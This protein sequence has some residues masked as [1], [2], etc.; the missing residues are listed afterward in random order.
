M[1]KASASRSSR[2]SQSLAS[3]S[4]PSRRIFSYEDLI[5]HGKPYVPMARLDACE[6]LGDRD[7]L[8]NDIEHHIITE[9]IPV[10]ISNVL[11][12]T[13]KD[14]S[15]VQWNRQ[16]FAPD[17][18]EQNWPKEPITPRHLL[19]LQDE[20]GFTVQAYLEIVRNA[21]MRSNQ[22]SAKSLYAH[23]YPTVYAKDL[24][25]PKE[26]EDHMR[27]ILDERLIYNGPTDCFGDLPEKLRAINLMVYMGTE[28]TRT[29]S[30]TDICSS[31]GHN[32]MVYAEDDA[33]SIWFVA[34]RKNKEKACA[35]WSL[36]KGSVE[37]DDN[38]VTLERFA[39]SEFDVFV[40]KQRLG[41]FVL[42]PSDS[43]HQVVNKGGLSVKMAWNRHT[44]RSLYRFFDCGLAAH[45]QDICKTETYRNK[46]MVLHAIEK[47]HAC[48]ESKLKPFLTGGQTREEDLNAIEPITRELAQTLGELCLLLKLY[49]SLILDEII[50]ND[51]LD[52]NMANTKQMGLPDNVPG[53]RSCDFCHQDIF[54]HGYH[55]SHCNTE[56]NG[57]IDETAGY[58]MCCRCFGMGRSCRE[59]RHLELFSHYSLREL[60]DK[61]TRSHQLI[62]TIT[63]VESLK[64]LTAEARVWKNAMHDEM[65]FSDWRAKHGERASVAGINLVPAPPYLHASR[66]PGGKLTVGKNKAETRGLATVA[67]DRYC[68][69]KGNMP[70]DIISLSSKIKL[71]SRSTTRFTGQGLEL[72]CH[73]CGEQRLFAL[74]VCSMPDCNMAYCQGCMNTKYKTRID[75]VV[76]ERKWQC[77]HCKRQCQKEGCPEY[78]PDASGELKWVLPTVLYNDW[79]IDKRNRGS[80]YDWELVKRKQVLKSEAHRI[81]AR[82]I[83]G[84]RLKQERS[85]QLQR[86]QASSD[87][88]KVGEPIPL[89]P[90]D[91]SAPS[92]CASKHKA[93]PSSSAAAS[94]KLSAESTRSSTSTQ[95]TSNAS[96]GST[97]SQRSKSARPVVADSDDEI[98]RASKKPAIS[99]AAAA[100]NPPPRTPSATPSP[101]RE[102]PE[103]DK[104]ESKRPAVRPPRS[105]RRKSSRKKP[106]AAT[107]PAPAPAPKLT[108]Q[109]RSRR[110]KLV[111]KQAQ[112]PLDD[113]LMEVDP[114]DTIPTP[115]LSNKDP[116][117]I[118]PMQV[119]KLLPPESSNSESDLSDI[120]SDFPD[121]ASGESESQ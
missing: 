40:V 92:T 119:D 22:S 32:I 78:K 95:R 51:D 70:A 103:Q 86:M 46:T 24:A 1:V 115:P 89:P 54:N 12:A 110:R 10:V 71:A 56:A 53:T 120:D 102:K 14:A 100:P 19:N 41:D 94:S 106:A 108:M 117:A 62:K 34:A 59:P 47:R 48:L 36:P 118:A 17:W 76:R 65:A 116:P 39:N 72:V 82:M 5:K 28:R 111:Q 88:V 45:Y 85:L 7:K 87:N 79:S 33:Y 63:K 43:V 57:V 75:Q 114:T 77:W 73:H 83:R 107:T 26:W 29:P 84:D 52:R 55:C 23:T 64:A 61:Y 31:L 60:N 16:L 69:L 112:L 58:D 25:C 68:R 3:S 38:Y 37:L 30:H 4:Q 8:Y 9:G 121:S 97:R 67:Y 44:V 90:E 80:W 35:Q 74:Y 6:Y 96:S 20:P 11:Q 13:E 50:E 81:R 49:Q 101:E 18:I 91:A 21:R 113:S 66:E 99:V 104:A 105:S 93:T 27:D 2:Q 109:T 15:L 98:P 42:L